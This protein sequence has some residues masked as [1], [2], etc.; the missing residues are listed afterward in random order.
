MTGVDHPLEENNNI[1]GMTWGISDDLKP[2]PKKKRVKR[3]MQT[4]TPIISDNN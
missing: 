4:K 2:K 3:G 1:D